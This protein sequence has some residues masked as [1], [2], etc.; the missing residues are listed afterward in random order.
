VRLRLGLPLPLRLPLTPPTTMM[1]MMMGMMMNLAPQWHRNA[2]AAAIVLLVVL[3]LIL[4]FPRRFSISCWPVSLPPSGRRAVRGLVGC[5][6][7]TAATN[8]H[9][10]H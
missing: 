6:Q 5:K 8:E 9:R 1:S 2:S 7:P 3:L 10:K 4:S